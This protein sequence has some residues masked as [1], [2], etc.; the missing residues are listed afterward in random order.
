MSRTTAGIL[1]ATIA[2]LLCGGCGGDAGPTRYSVSGEVTI[3]GVPVP[4]GR[5]LFTPD[6]SAG[7]RGPQGLARICNGRFSTNED[8]EGKGAGSGA[9]LVEIH[10][11]DG[12]PFQGGEGEVADGKAL[13]P[14]FRKTVTL[15]AASC[16]MTVDVAVSA[17][18][19]QA[20]VKI[21]P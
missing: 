6:V 20:E 1:L 9:Y 16:T 21:S 4:A 13:F 11:C 14:P 5:L 7:N 3:N 10:G 19:P 12:I 2:G 17:D 18:G 8:A 15:P